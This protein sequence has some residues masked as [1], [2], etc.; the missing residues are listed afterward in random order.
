[1]FEVDGKKNKV[2][3]HVEPS[4]LQCVKAVGLVECKISHYG[5]LQKVSLD[6][7]RDNHVAQAYL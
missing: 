3:I 7:L 5:N 6:T 4:D 2:V 1:V